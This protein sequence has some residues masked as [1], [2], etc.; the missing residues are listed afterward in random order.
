MAAIRGERQEGD[1]SDM[2][3]DSHE[4]R[5]CAKEAVQ[6]AKV[7]MASGKDVRLRYAALELRQAMEALV[8]DRALAFKDDVPPDQY[9][10]WQ[11]KKLMGL[12]LQIDPTLDF[13][14]TMAV[15]VQPDLHTPAPRESM[16]VMGTDTPVTLK[17]L[18]DHYDALGSFLH[19]PSLGQLT[20]GRLPDASRLRERCE[21]LV[22][23]LEK[24]L[25]SRIWNSTLGF[26]ATLPECVNEDCK[27]PIKRR[28]PFDKTE[29]ETHCFSCNAEY[30]IE[31]ATGENSVKWFPKCRK[32]KC[33]NSSCNAT[34]DMWPHQERAG[35]YWACD[36][37]GLENEL[38]LV[39]RLTP[40]AV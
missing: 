10:T 9:K 23:V 8:Y 24:V 30:R 1:N 31:Y 39:H 17:N 37:C 35:A 29:M 12:L 32:V 38:V 16:R 19:M 2:S 3:V 27:Q 18:K 25:S 5:G 7:E 14:S 36:T 6:R 15:G 33:A 11:P 20:T 22:S 34:I 40:A 28:L 4:L 26:Y 21:T 13:A